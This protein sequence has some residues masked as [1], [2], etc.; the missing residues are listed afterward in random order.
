MRMAA[1]ETL[2]AATKDDYH[3]SIRWLNRHR[4]YLNQR[5]CDR[6]NSA[7]ERIR[8]EPMEVGEVMIQ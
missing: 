1:I 7:L 3:P 2:E 6:V 4:F 8:S 5:E